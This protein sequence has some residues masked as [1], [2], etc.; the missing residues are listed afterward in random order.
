[1][2]NIILL[3]LLLPVLRMEGAALELEAPTVP[4]SGSALMPKESESFL[5]GLVELFQNVFLRLQPDLAEALH[6]AVTLCCMVMIFTLLQSPGKPPEK[7]AI[8]SGTAAITSALLKSA[9]SLIQLA[10]TTILEMSE[11]GKLLLPVMTAALVT[12]GGTATS[13][14]LYTGTA[15]FDVV[16]TGLISRLLVPA[17]YMFLALAAANS[18]TGEDVLKQFR[19]LLKGGIS[20]TLKTLLTVFT[21]YMSI[22]GVISGTTDAVKLKAAKFTI[23]SVVPVVGGILSDAS[24]ALLV[25]A[26]LV[27]N[28]AG[29]YGILAILAVFLG[30]FVKIW[31]QYAVL[32]LT[33]ALC[34]LFCARPLADLIESFSTAMGLLLAMAGS[35]CLLLLVSTICFLKGV[36]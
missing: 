4:D 20:W 11:Y 23:S 25:S 36:G 24:E 26:G 28:T 17:V 32:K 12:Q 30:P 15:A 5:D 35:V 31:I 3:F 16:L 19:D 2:R 29:I 1:M 6:T 33:A 9:N 18:A 13:A 22:S 10:S 7:I 14:A 27:K 21:T 34:S 8:L